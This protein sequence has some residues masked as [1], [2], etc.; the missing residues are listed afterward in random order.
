[1][2]S[3]KSQWV[4][5]MPC[6]DKGVR[7]RNKKKNR[8]EGPSRELRSPTTNLGWFAGNNALSHTLNGHTLYYYPQ[9]V[10]NNS[11]NN[12]IQYCDIKHIILLL[13]YDNACTSVVQNNNII[14]ILLCITIRFCKLKIKY[15][16]YVCRKALIET[17]GECF[18]AE[19]TATI[20]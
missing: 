6:F 19:T 8:E 10:Y 16:L 4:S 1:M 17:I 5:E 18:T 7:D 2:L 9:H 3:Q 15:Q 20:L 13:Q 14:R 11:N 12:N